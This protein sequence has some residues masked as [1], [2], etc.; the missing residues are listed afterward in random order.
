[1]QGESRPSS[2]QAFFLFFSISLFVFCRDH[3]PRLE[4]TVIR[5]REAFRDVGRT[6]RDARRYPGAMPFILASFPY[7]DAIGTIVS[8]MAIYAVKAMGFA[9]GTETTLF[10]VL[11][12]P[13]IFGS[14]LACR[15]V[16][17]ALARSAR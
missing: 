14:Y 10:L 5:W 1:M 12:I 3:P 13:A 4:K 2:P 11:T 6:L 7:Q 16:G 15:L 17:T 8:F 9:R